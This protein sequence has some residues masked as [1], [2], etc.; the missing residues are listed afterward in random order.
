MVNKVTLI[1]NLGKDPE[2]FGK[3]NLVTKFSLATSEHYK[4]EKKT[5]WHNIICFGKTGEVALQYLKKG[6]KVYIDGRI[7]YDKW[8]KDG[9]T[10]YSTSIIVNSL[11]FLDAKGSTGNAGQPDG[12][13]TNPQEQPFGTDEDLPF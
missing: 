5:S 10:R 7:Q 8:E 4:G 1:G 6:S 13:P 2:S 9:V 12:K 3:D 11:Q